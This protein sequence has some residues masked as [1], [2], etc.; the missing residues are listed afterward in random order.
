MRLR[1]SCE[2]SRNGCSPLKRALPARSCASTLTTVQNGL[3]SSPDELSN[4]QTKID[5]TRLLVWTLEVGPQSRKTWQAAL[6][7]D[8]PPRPAYI[9]AVAVGDLVRLPEEVNEARRP[10]GG[11]GVGPLGWHG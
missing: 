7:L 11:T 2:R 1:M 5:R 10:S 9:G 6:G 8:R 3:A 4:L